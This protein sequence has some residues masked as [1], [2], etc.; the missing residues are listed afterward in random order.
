MLSVQ[1]IETNE[2]SGLTVALAVVMVS[3]VAK[4]GVE[5]S[6]LRWF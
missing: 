1:E 4:H 5:F 2:L 3:L 6:L